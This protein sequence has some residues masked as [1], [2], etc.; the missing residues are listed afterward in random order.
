VGNDLKLSITIAGDQ[1][2]ASAFV[3]LR[4]FERSIRK[5]GEYGYDGVE[6]ALKKASEVNPTELS[7]WLSNCGIEVSAISTGQVFAD[8]GLYFTSIDSD[9]RRHATK[10]FK[11]LID[12]A[13]DFGGIVNVGRARGFI[14]EGQSKDAAESLFLTAMEDLCDYAMN[15]GV[16]IVVEPVNRYEINFINSVEEGV[17]FVS[18]L[19]AHNSG[20]MPDVFHMNIEDRLIGGSFHKY[21]QWIKY[22]HLADSNRW[23]PGQGHLDFNDIFNGLRKVHYNGWIS[24]ETLPYPDPDTAARQAAEFLLPYV[25]AHNND[26]RIR[27]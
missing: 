1:A 18:R 3:V 25:V 5:A 20:V 13:S 9:V 24:V 17:G 12:L 27:E 10:V 11:E 21:A 2:K 14:A 6:L 4:G 16:T 22:V 19:K 23:A 26:K 7:R 8:L 15:R